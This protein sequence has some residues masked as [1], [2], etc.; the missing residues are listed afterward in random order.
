MRFWRLGAAL[1]VVSLLGASWAWACSPWL[2]AA[3]PAPGGGTESTSSSGPSVTIHTFQF[4]PT[5]LEVQ[6][7][8]RVTWMN[9]DDITHTITSGVPGKQDG[10]FDSR[11]DGKGSTFSYTFTQPGTYPYY[12][13]RHQSMRGEVHVK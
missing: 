12:C 13:N 3:A 7:G 11:L 2:H 8:T 5:P 9:Q 1:A 10:G 4:S 6:A